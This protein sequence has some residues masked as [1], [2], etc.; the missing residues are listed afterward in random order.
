MRFKFGFIGAGNMGG[1]LL[2]SVAQKL[3]FGQVC[4]TDHHPEKLQTAVDVYGV[5]PTDSKTLALNS[6]FIVMGVKPQVMAKAFDEIKEELSVNKD[7]V[8]ISM[9]AG[10]S[11]S[12]IEALAGGNRAVI[13]IMPNTPCAVSE[14][15]I[16]YTANDKVNADAIKNFVSAFTL[17]GI[18]DKLDEQKMDAGMALS[19][20]SPAF[21]YM[22]AEALADSA[23]LCGLPREKAVAYTAKVLIGAGRMIEEYGHISDLKDAVCSPGGTTIEGVH[24]LEQGGMRGVVMD[25]VKKSFEKSKQLKK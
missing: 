2:L 9:A 12:D 7:A 23:V 10:L 6:D 13:R 19:G 20:C 25:A 1:T 17:A 8:I 16:L 14:G 3:G 24:A 21:T 15:V 11:T 4:A 18:L 5:F 22:F